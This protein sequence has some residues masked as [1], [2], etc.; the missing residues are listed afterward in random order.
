MVPLRWGGS[1]RGSGVEFEEQET[2][3][4]TVRDGSIC[5]VKEYTTKRA[6]LDAVGLR[7]P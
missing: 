3:V 4:F 7:G 1:G 6:A 5:R 2:W